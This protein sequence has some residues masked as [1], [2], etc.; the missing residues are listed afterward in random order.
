MHEGLFAPAGDSWQLNLEHI[1]LFLDGKLVLVPA[2]LRDFV[3]SQKWG[4]NKMEIAYLIWSTIYSATKYNC[5]WRYRSIHNKLYDFGATRI[6]NEARNTLIEAGFIQQPA[7]RSYK[8]NSHSLNFRAPHHGDVVPVV[9]EV[10]SFADCKGY[11]PN[12]EKDEHV[13]YTRECLDMLEIDRAHMVEG[14]QSIIA[15]YKNKKEA[16]ARKEERQGA[17]KKKKEGIKN[18]EEALMRLGKPLFELIHKTGKITRSQPKKGHRL[19]SPYAFL[20]TE[21]RPLFT[22]GGQKMAFV[23]AVESQVN[24]LAN[25]SSDAQ[26]IED[27][28]NRRFYQRVAEEFDLRDEKGQI[29]R[30]EGKGP[31]YKYA[32]ADY[33]PN[34]YLTPYMAERYPKADQFMREQKA[35]NYKQASWLL[36]GFESQIFLDGVYTRLRKNNIP[37][38]SIHDGIATP[39]QYG[40]EVKEI[41]EEQFTAENIKGKVL[42]EVL[43][44]IVDIFSKR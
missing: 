41:V 24:L 34:F 5:S 15:G 4:T 33:R 23:D 42:V 38:I 7:R 32:F 29:H 20:M 19:F 43:E 28:C 22:F 12:Y 25:L 3:K 21:F 35:E 17:R 39:E 2:S 1:Q 44:P 16:R 31:F 18:A 8:K 37:A 10:K 13:A 11:K 14:V 9:L 36:Q 6:V 26:L 27:T 30:N 40:Q